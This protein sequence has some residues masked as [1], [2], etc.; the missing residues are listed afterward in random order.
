VKAATISTTSAAQLTAIH[1]API[2]GE[3]PGDFHFHRPQQ[4]Y[5]Y[6]PSGHGM[7]VSASFCN[8]GAL[9]MQRIIAQPNEVSAL[10]SSPAAMWLSSFLTQQ[11]ALH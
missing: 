3:I 8:V 9:R 6:H 2:T 10:Y 4:Q 11:A 1:Q 7:A 5:R